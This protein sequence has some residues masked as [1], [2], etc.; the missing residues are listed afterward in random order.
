LSRRNPL[1][2]GTGI[3]VSTSAATQRM[4]SGV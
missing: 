2:A 3:E 1:A 4:E